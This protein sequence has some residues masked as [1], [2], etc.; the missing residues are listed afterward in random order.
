MSEERPAVRVHVESMTPDAF[1]G[2]SA[3]RPR[4]KVFCRPYTVVL[5]STITTETILDENDKR[6]YALVAAGGNDVIINNSKA[7]AQNEAN[8]TSGLPNPIGFYL[9]AGFTTPTKIP[10]G[11]KWYATAA[12]YPA[13]ITV[14]CVEEED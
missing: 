2:M 8:T 5:T 6:L 11:Q 7:E 1:T 13:Q 14:L 4:K 10:G 3:P 9:S 12:A